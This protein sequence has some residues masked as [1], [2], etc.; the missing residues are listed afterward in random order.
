ME[1]T[2]FKRNLIDRIDRC[3]YQMSQIREIAD[4]LGLDHLDNDLYKALYSRKK[5]LTEMLE[6]LVEE[7][8]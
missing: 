2:Q 1:T 7:R 3:R 5:V 6:E 4:E 8:K